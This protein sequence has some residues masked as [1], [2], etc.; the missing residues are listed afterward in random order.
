MK[1]KSTWAIGF[2]RKNASTRPSLA[3]GLSMVMMTYSGQRMRLTYGPEPR[4]AHFML[5]TRTRR[6]RRINYQYANLKAHREDIWTNKSK[7][8]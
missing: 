7:T 5:A 6:P 1:K 4:R 2:I 3:V 8:N